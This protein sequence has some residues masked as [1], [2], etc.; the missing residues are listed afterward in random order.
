MGSVNYFGKHNPS[1]AIIL[2][3]LYSY[4]DYEIH[5]ILSEFPVNKLIFHNI[6]SSILGPLPSSSS[7]SELEK[8]DKSDELVIDLTPNEQEE[9]EQDDNYNQLIPQSPILPS[10]YLHNSSKINQLASLIP[11]LIQQDHRF[12]I[13]F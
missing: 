2:E 7:S 5:L 6:S 8:N 3:E 11:S 13:S 4:S 9:E 10:S 12:V 1:L